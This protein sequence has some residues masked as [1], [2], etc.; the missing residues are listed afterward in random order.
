MHQRSC[1]TR[2]LGTAANYSNCLLLTVRRAFELH[3][4][5]TDVIVHQVYLP[6]AHHSA[7]SCYITRQPGQ[8]SE[9]RTAGQHDCLQLHDVHLSALAGGSHDNPASQLTYHQAVGG[10]NAAH[11][12]GKR[13]WQSRYNTQFT[14]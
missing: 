10:T 3:V 14:Q 13:H 6:V 2:V 4:Q 5:L 8:G 1:V 11:Q 9:A 12:I 7:Q